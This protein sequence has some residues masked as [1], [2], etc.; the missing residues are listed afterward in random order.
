MIKLSKVIISIEP[1]KTEPITRYNERVWRWRIW[2]DSDRPDQWYASQTEINAWNEWS[3]K[4]RE[5][6]FTLGS[7]DGRFQARREEFSYENN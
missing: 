7:N 3:K 4:E 6:R 1:Y 5:A 2:I